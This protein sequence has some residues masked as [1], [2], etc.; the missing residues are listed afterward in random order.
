MTMT[1]SSTTTRSEDLRRVVR[2]LVTYHDMLPRPQGQVLVGDRPEMVLVD[3]RALKAV[4]EPRMRVPN[5]NALISE[6]EANG[7]LAI[8]TRE[9]IWVLDLLRATMAIEDEPPPLA[10]ALE[11]CE[12]GLTALSAFAIETAYGN[13]VYVEEDPAEYQRALSLLGRSSFALPVRPEPIP[14]SLQL[15]RWAFS[16]AGS[17]W[18]VWQAASVLG[19]AGDRIVAASEELADTGRAQRIETESKRRDWKK[20]A[21]IH[22][23]SKA[24]VT[25]ARYVYQSGPL[26]IA[27]VHWLLVDGLA[28]FTARAALRVATVGGLAGLRSSVGVLEELG[29]IRYLPNTDGR[30]GENFINRSWAVDRIETPDPSRAAPQRGKLAEEACLNAIRRLCRASAAQPPTTEAIAKH[31]DWDAVDTRAALDR[32]LAANLVVQH[33][34]DTPTLN[35]AGRVGRG[36]AIRWSVNTSVRI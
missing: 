28:S 30:T 20:Y 33:R 31:A 35:K 27:L 36:K 14:D 5:W 25:E 29:W 17:T 32:L 1:M 16:H 34:F 9:E 11:W 19:W 12:A 21:L 26:A 23:P 13:L 6:L 22:A 18:Y 3:R 10:E 24:D 7:A 4:I 8:T 2:A 15:Y